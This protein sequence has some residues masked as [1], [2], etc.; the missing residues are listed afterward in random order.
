MKK[1]VSVILPFHDQNRYLDDAIKSILSSKNVDVQLILVDDRKNPPVDKFSKMAAIKTFGVGYSEAVNKGAKQVK[2]AYVGLMNSDDISKSK[3]LEIQL[4]ILSDHKIDIS[5]TKLQNTSSSLRYQRSI[6]GDLISTDPRTSHL[7]VGSHL[8]NA[9]WM[10]KSDYWTKNC[11]FSNIGIGADWYLATELITD[12]NTSY[13]NE[14]LYYYR[15]HSNQSTSQKFH[16]DNN[17]RLKW[18]SLN[19]KLGYPP[20]NPDFGVSLVFPSVTNADV[21]MKHLVTEKMVLNWYAEYKKN[22]STNASKIAARRIAASLF[23]NG[24]T[25]IIAT[26]RDFLMAL[27]EMSKDKAYN[28]ALKLLK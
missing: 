21:K 26:E 11:T 15:K 28:S 24:L 4:D 7:L 12:T 20:L 25:K 23:R 8:A 27:M 10:T 17:L 14:A 2:C 18:K 13:H 22:N 5:V 3:R 6:G 19:E 9:T 1:E 16:L